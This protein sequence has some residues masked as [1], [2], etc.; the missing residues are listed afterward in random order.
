MIVMIKQVLIATLLLGVSF[1][2]SLYAHSIVARIAEKILNTDDKDKLLLQKV[3]DKLEL[4][5]EKFKEIETSNSLLEAAIT[6]DILNFDFQGFLAKYHF[7]DTPFRY[8]ND[9]PN[10]PLPDIEEVNAGKALKDAKALIEDSY[11]EPS[12][13]KKRFL[14][15]GTVDSIM[16]RYVLHVTGDVH[17]PL[18]TVSMFSNSLMD[19]KIKKGDR[20]GNSILIAYPGNAALMN[21][22]SLWDGGCGL[23]KRIDPPDFPFNQKMK[24]ELDKFAV[25]LMEEYPLSWFGKLATDTNYDNWIKESNDIATSFTYSEIGILPTLRPE[26]LVRCRDI[27]RERVTLAGYRLASFLKEVFANAK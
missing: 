22:H 16:T 11:K 12:P 26:Y 13:K 15:F 23:F 3:Y 20:G 14:S 18:H 2:W 10:F 8:K 7:K 25:D 1:S 24:D 6:P 17:Q 27:S 21:L 4:M 5:H 19:G 9:D